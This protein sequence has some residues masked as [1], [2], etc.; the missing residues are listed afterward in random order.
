MKRVCTLAIIVLLLSSLLACQAPV[1]PVPDTPATASDFDALFSSENHIEIHLD[2]AD[3][4]LAKMQSDYERYSSMGSK[5]PI[6]RRANLSLTITCPNNVVKEFHITDVGVRMK[7]NTSRE[8]FYSQEAGMYSLIHLKLSFNETFDNAAYYG[9]DVTIWENEA[10][11]LARKERTFATLEK[12]DLRWNRNDDT[13]YI[14]E[15]Y[16]YDIYREFGVLAPETNL[17]SV[18]IGDDHAGVFTIYEPVDKQFLERH[19]PKAAEGGDLYKLRWSTNFTSF[20]SYGVENED[21]NQFY[22][23]DLKTNKSTSSHKALENL[24]RVMNGTS[25]TK[26]QISSVLDMDNFLYY[27]AVSYII[28]NPDDLR[29]NY[30]NSYIYFRPDTGK[31]MV[32]PYDLDRGLGVNTWNPYGNGMTTDSPFALYNVMGRQQNPLFTKTVTTGGLFLEEYKEA[33]Q[34]VMEHSILSNVTF[35]SAFAQA[36]ALYAKDTTPS[37]TYHNCAYHNFRFDINKTALAS[38]SANMSYRDYME[39]KLETLASALSGE[40]LGEDIKPSLN[41]DLFIRA[42]FTNWEMDNTYHM[43]E[44]EDGIS[45]ITLTRGEEFRFKIYNDVNGGWYG[46]ECMS[47]DCGAPYESD[48][49]TNIVLGAGTY[50]V[51]YDKYTNTIFLTKT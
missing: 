42:D 25:L 32:I 12:L 35:A 9:S 10:D 13:T 24:I 21:Q 15:G 4:E 43:T 37:K 45:T 47:P 34:T 16:S 29:N 3:S 49:H 8:N 40:D 33:L 17:A 31:M 14:R 28:G 44:N 51:S 46:T 50:L 48:G 1:P 26:E 23:Y 36:K 41:V 22:N 5:S 6:Y 7:G 11:R 19:L 27:A 20:S 38:D 30:N 39:I 2:I 18:N